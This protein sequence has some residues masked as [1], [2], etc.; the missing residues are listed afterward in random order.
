MMLVTVSVAT[1]ICITIK[2]LL[3]A[4]KLA[5]LREGLD[6]LKKEDSDEDEDDEEE[7]VEKPFEIAPINSENRKLTIQRAKE[8]AEKIKKSIKTD[9]K[10]NKKRLNDVYRY[11]TDFTQFIF[12]FFLDHYRLRSI[13]NEI[14]QQ[15]EKSLK[16]QQ[17]KKQLKEEKMFKPAVLSRHKYEPPELELNLTTEICGS[18]RQMKV[19]CCFIFCIDCCLF[20]IASFVLTVVALR[21]CIAYWLIVVTLQPEGNILE[22]RYKSLQRRNIV[23]PRIFFMGQKRKYAK[24]KFEKRDCKEVTVDY[25]PRH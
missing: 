21:F 1:L 23:E 24:K 4:S 10:M 18:L 17:K 11:C 13:K 20:V 12:K 8:N 14:K 16:K 22:D 2:I 5:E 25:V 7:N 19:T 15:D 3:Q 9:D 6:L